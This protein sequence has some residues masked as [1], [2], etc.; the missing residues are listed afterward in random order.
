MGDSF[1][2]TPTTAEEVR[3]PMSAYDLI[4]LQVIMMSLPKCVPQITMALADAIS[5]SFATGTFP[6]S[7][8]IANLI[9]IYKRGD[10]ED[11]SN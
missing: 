11:P 8:N 2:L 9:Q 6:N 7:L 1:C 4:K 5:H 10:H 3:T